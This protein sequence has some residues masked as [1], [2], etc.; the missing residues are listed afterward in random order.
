M[1]AEF[2]LWAAIF[3]LLLKLMKGVYLSFSGN[4]CRAHQLIIDLPSGW[5]GIKLCDP[6]E[7]C[8]HPFPPPSTSETFPQE[9]QGKSVS[10]GGDISS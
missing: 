2:G 3:C 9:M 5:A 10:R 1:Q 4:C 7:G 8:F 6:R